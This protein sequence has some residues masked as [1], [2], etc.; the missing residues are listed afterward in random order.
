MPK[1][2]QPSKK[3]QVA[4]RREEICKL[5][6]L[7]LSTRKIAEQLGCSESTVREDIKTELAKVIS[8]TSANFVELRAIE[9]Q[10]LELPLAALAPKVEAGDPEACEIWRKY[11]AERRKLLGLDSQGVQSTGGNMS[12]TFNLPGARKIV[13]S[14]EVKPEPIMLEIPTGGTDASK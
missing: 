12:F 10:R 1:A 14:R 4:L 13:E 2:K 11:S 3:L 9:L 6:K 7:Q 5:A 8:R